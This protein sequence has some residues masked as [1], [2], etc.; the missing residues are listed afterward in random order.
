M[1]SNE[2][3]T[4]LN[5]YYTNL[6]LLK[7]QMKPKFGFIKAAAVLMGSMILFACGGSG[8]SGA[9]SG[10]GSSAGLALTKSD[11]IGKWG[12]CLAAEG[13][14]LGLLSTFNEDSTVTNVQSAYGNTNCDASNMLTQDPTETDSFK[15]GAHL[16]NQTVTVDGV[17]I[18]LTNVTEID[19]TNRTAGDEDFGQ[20]EYTII[21]IQDG[22]KLFLGDSTG[23][24]T[25][26]TEALRPTT[27]APLPFVKTVD[28]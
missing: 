19:T 8:S 25:G 12:F 1:R 15:L 18:T 24:L 14:S 23:Q 2:N 26:A 13:V 7:T 28:L 27:I 10:T 5:R 11:L 3:L 17:V 22:A 4:I 9:G 6:T 20:I 16:P 21:A